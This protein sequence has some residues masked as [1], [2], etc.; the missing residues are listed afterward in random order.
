[1]PVV[2]HLRAFG[3]RKAHSAKNI[4]QFV[5]HLAHGVVAA[6]GYGPSGSRRVFC[7]DDH[8]GL[9][10]AVLQNLGFNA[11]FKLIKKLTDLPAVLGFGQ[12]EVRKKIVE[13]ALSTQ[14]PKTQEFRLIGVG[15]SRRSDLKEVLLYFSLHSRVN[16][17]ICLL[18]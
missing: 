11:G 17:Y 16:C 13:K 18:C 15:R 1:M 12:L 2:L 7:A 5:A 10:G 3:H 14:K 9:A 6:G 8:L 4:D